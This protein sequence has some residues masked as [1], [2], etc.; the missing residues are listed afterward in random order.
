M[1]LLR[2]ISASTRCQIC[3]ITA[4]WSGR[5]GGERV[6]LS[7]TD[8]ES[9]VV[10]EHWRDHQQAISA[11]EISDTGTAQAGPVVGEVHKVAV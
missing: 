3:E 9:H 2:K 6:E 7:P 1:Q 4:S 11:A 10:C 8:H 5:S